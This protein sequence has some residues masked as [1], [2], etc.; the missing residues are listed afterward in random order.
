M[1]LF[2]AVVQRKGQ[3]LRYKKV[4]NKN[5]ELVEIAGQDQQEQQQ[6]AAQLKANKSKRII[7]WFRQGNGEKKRLSRS[8]RS[9]L[10]FSV[11]RLVISSQT[12]STAKGPKKSSVVVFIMALFTCSPIAGPCFPARIPWPHMENGSTIGPTA[13]GLYD[14]RQ[15]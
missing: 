4:N 5:L 6:P 8:C 7:K 15:P 1:L 2:E 3:S 12:P 11:G 14:H 9:E 10:D 13:A